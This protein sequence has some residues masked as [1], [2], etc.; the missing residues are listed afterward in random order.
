MKIKLSVNKKELNYGDLI[1][2]NGGGK[3]TALY[4]GYSNEFD[5]ALY[6]FTDCEIIAIS[7]HDEDLLADVENFLEYEYGE[8][9]I[10]IIPNSKLVLT[11]IDEKQSD[12]E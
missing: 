1:I 2:T 9:I 10:C 11:D 3:Y 12:N 6:S 8:D 4:N 5:Y 7:H